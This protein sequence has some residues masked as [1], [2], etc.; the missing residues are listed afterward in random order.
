MKEKANKYL[1]NAID[2]LKDANFELYRPVEDVVSFSVCK[3]A[4]FAID[5]YLRG[6]L[7]K[8]NVDAS[9]YKTINELYEQ[10]KNINNKFERID[11]STFD[12]TT[13]EIDSKYCNEVSRVSQCY[14]TADMLDNLLREERIIG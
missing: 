8:N 6:Y 10:C 3:N 12:C 2:K 9:S 11:L 4:Q 1:Q 13:T 7:L 5:N 14:K